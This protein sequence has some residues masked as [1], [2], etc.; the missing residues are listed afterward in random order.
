MNDT[1]KANFTNILRAAFAHP[2][3]KSAKKTVTLS[4]FFVLL[5]SAHPKL[6]LEH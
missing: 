4:V 2:D 3:P 1:A 5:R 6:L